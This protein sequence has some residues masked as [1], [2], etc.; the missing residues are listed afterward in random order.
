MANRQNAVRITQFAESRRHILIK[1]SVAALNDLPE[2]LDFSFVDADHSYEGCT[3]DLHAYW[4]RV[5][6]GGLFSG[7]DYYTP[8]QRSEKKLHAE[9]VG[10]AVEEFF[11]EKGLKF[12]VGAGTVWW[13][14]K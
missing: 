4:P 6:S 7:H 13:V 12:S 10:R 9:G 14:W 5:R 1:D 3:R 8:Q 2:S 11:E